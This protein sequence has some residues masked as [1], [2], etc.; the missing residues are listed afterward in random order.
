LLLRRNRTRTFLICSIVLL[1]HE[2]S[3]CVGER[4]PF[5]NSFNPIASTVLALPNRLSI[6]INRVDM[7]YVFAKSMPTRVIS[8]ICASHPD[9]KLNI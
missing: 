7:K 5:S 2:K 1:S 6:F 8:A 4:L 9:N 3:S